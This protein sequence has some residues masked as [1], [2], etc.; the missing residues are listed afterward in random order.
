MLLFLF[1]F[2]F[3]FSPHSYLVAFFYIKIWVP[4]EKINGPATTVL[5]PTSTP[6]AYLKVPTT[7]ISLLLLCLLALQMRL[8][9]MRGKPW[10]GPGWTPK[11]KLRL[12][13]DMD[14]SYQKVATPAATASQATGWSLRCD[15]HVTTSCH[16]WTFPWLFGSF[17]KE[18]TL[19]SHH[20][21]CSLKSCWAALTLEQI[22][23]N[24]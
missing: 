20:K 15:P 21:S 7:F 13:W 23:E 18:Q 3:F 16:L 9:I 10:H 11:R 19:A 2:F 17:Q 1:A 14:I 12:W 5:A 22:L 4:C 24:F 6:Q 8:L